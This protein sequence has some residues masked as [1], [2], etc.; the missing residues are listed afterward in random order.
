M[1]YAILPAYDSTTKARTKIDDI[2]GA[3]VTIVRRDGDDYLVRGESL[4]DFYWVNV[5]RIVPL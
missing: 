1:Q 2:S 5:E 4:T 3:I